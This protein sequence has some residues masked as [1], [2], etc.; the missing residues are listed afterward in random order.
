MNV[1][2]KPQSLLRCLAFGAAALCSPASAMAVGH[3]ADKALECQMSE[4][5]MAWINKSIEA[6]HH[7]HETVTHASRAIDFDALFFDD[8]CQMTSS[9][10]LIKRGESHWKRL[11]HN[12]AVTFPNGET[13]PPIVTS[14]TFADDDES[15]PAFFVMSVPSVWQK[16]GVKSDMGLEMLMTPVML[17][18]AIHGIQSG[19]YGKKIAVLSKKYN[20]PDS[21]ND[22]SLQKI[23]GDDEGYAKSIKAENDLFLEAAFAETDSEVRALALKARKLIQDRHEKWFVGDD[24]KYREID[25]L[26]LTMEGSGQWVGYKWLSDPMGG[27]LDKQTAIKEFGQRGKWWSQNLGFALFMVIDR[28]SVDWREDAF[29]S[30]NRTA[31]TLLDDALQE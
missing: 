18:E 30:G 29:S 4:T 20:L 14:F 15:Q 3:A 28:L 6:W 21:F 2:G 22:D 24:R 26:W 19:T 5:D 17:H 9:D 27:K 11:R 10:A 31:L 8:T 1:F 16:G 23:F 13:V 12:D 7:M 25:D